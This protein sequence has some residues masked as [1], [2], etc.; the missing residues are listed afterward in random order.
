VLSSGRGSPAVRVES[1][2]SSF[3][4]PGPDPNVFLRLD[5]PSGSGLEHQR[6]R[7]AG[8]RERRPLPSSIRRRHSRW[9]LLDRCIT[10]RRDHGGL[11]F[12]YAGRY[13]VQLLR[14][15][16]PGI[17]RQ[18]ISSRKTP[19]VARAHQGNG[20]TS[21]IRIRGSRKSGYKKMGVL[22]RV[23]KRG[24]VKFVLKVSEDLWSDK[25][26]T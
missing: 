1:C 24:R 17:S 11:P 3:R 15:H 4:H 25:K 12:Q 2:F 22:R 20:A 18:G 6:Q 7:C 19:Q 13:R 10:A 5:I 14:L 23:R 26:R 9:I 21:A 16:R 8:V